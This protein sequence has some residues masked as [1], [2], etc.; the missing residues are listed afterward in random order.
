VWAALVLTG[1]G[2][3]LLLLPLQPADRP[4][5][6]W[7]VLPLAWAL[8]MWAARQFISQDPA[9]VPSQD[10]M[11]GATTGGRA[12]VLFRER[13]SR[14][15]P[16]PYPVPRRCARG[17]LHARPARASGAPTVLA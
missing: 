12:A 14:R 1:L 15:T 8:V 7:L 11:S 13:P 10:P 3:G 6:T 5:E 17:R 9:A 2:D 4:W 16:A